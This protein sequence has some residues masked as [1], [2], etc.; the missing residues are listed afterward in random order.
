[1]VKTVTAAFCI[2]LFSICAT[3]ASDF[4]LEAGQTLSLR[5]AIEIALQNQP[6]LEAQHGQ[7]EAGEARIGQIRGDFLPRLTLGGAY[8]RISP[9]DAATGAATSSAGLPPGSQYIPTGAEDTY[10]QYAA[11]G[12]LNQLIFDFGKTWANLRAQKSNVQATLMDLQEMRDQ[13]ILAVKEAYY[14]L[15]IAR[16]SH[17]VAAEKVE[18]FK[19]HVRYAQ[20]LYDTGAKSKLDTTKAL[21]DLNNA[22]VDLIK[23]ENGVRYYRLA[24][25][26][27]LGLPDAPS[28][29]IQEDPFY[30]APRIDYEEALKKAYAGR[31][32]L[33]SMQKQR[34][35]AEQS[36]LAAERT[37]YPVISGNVNYTFVGTEFPIDHGWTAGIYMTVPLFSGFTTAY[38]VSENRANIAVVD[39]RMKELK[40]K[41]ALELEQAF[42]ALR[43][44]RERIQSTLV[45]IR[46]ARENL[47]LAMERYAAGLAIHVEVADAIF[48]NA[49]ARY[50]NISANYDHKIAAS[51]LEKAMGSS[52]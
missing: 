40:Q 13:V 38:K 50:A 34:E 42:L 3:D 29:S 14:N 39:A 24:L 44:S 7:I 23:A 36:L 15:L 8:T 37:H 22:Q 11:T 10:N 16:E 45:A 46:H 32:D 52:P 48:S 28:Y 41:I 35:S 20:A 27:A 30:E 25:N 33:L 17:D 5:E 43:E 18:L 49:N 19:Q 1:M 47:D 21:V 51:H 31:P 26:N 9:V 12:S 4:R 6:I 2:F